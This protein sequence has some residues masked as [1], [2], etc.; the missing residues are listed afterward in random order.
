MELQTDRQS[1]SMAETVTFHMHHMSLKEHTLSTHACRLK[2]TENDVLQWH[3]GRVGGGGGE[4]QGL[5]PPH[6]LGLSL[7]R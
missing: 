4:I 1:Q 3:I 6:N 7:M 2:F 5:E